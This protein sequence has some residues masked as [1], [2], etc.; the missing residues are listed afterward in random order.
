MQMGI[1]PGNTGLAGYSYRRRL[2]SSLG[3]GVRSGT[4]HG[5]VSKERQIR[6]GHD[7]MHK[8][9]GVREV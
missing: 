6:D 2:E 3:S 4:V 9:S 7:E 1:E 5:A 8:R